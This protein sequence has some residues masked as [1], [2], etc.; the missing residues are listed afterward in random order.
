MSY[1][2]KNN[3]EVCG[4]CN[5]CEL[6]D[7]VDRPKV[8][9]CNIRSIFVELLRIS[10]SFYSPINLNKKNKKVTETSKSQY[11][12]VKRSKEV[13]DGLSMKETLAFDEI[14]IT[15]GLPVI[16]ES[17]SQS[18]IGALGK[19]KTMGLIEFGQVVIN[20]SGG[21]CRP[22]KTVTIITEKKKSV[23]PVTENVVDNYTKGNLNPEDDDDLNHVTVNEIGYD[24][25]S[26]EN[27]TGRIMD[28]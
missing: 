16:V 10:C 14:R 25:V 7:L 5:Q 27:L 21:L 24:V 8:N 20:T 13:I 18:T 4:T 17:L 15:N 11:V 6:L 22:F 23:D 1:N 2:K 9:Y 3:S 12:S 28:D 26:E 19:L